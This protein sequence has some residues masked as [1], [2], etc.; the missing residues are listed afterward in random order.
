[1][2]DKLLFFDG[3]MGTMLQNKG[4][5]LGQLP[6]VLN[7]EQK[8]L[9]K[10]IH[11]SYVD[12]GADVITTNTF[13]ANGLK[14][15]GEP[16]SLEEIVKAAISAAKEVKPNYVALDIGPLGKLLEPAGDLS[17]DDAYQLFKEIAV[18][19]EKYQVDCVLIETM[20]DLLET[21]AAVLAVK[22]N[23]KLP[24]FVT[25][26][27]DETGRTF[28]GTDPKTATI[29]LNGL[30]VDGFGVNCS[31]GPKELMP[32]IKEI[33]KYSEAAVIVQPN[34]GLPKTDQNGN[35]YYDLT[36]EEYV[37]YMEIFYQAG[38]SV[39]G[40]C[41]GTTDKY[42]KALTE[43][44]KKAE[45]IKRTV[46]KGTYVTSYAKTVEI[47]KKIQLIGER[48]NPAGK[49]RLKKALKENDLDYILKEAIDQRDEGAT[50]LDVCVTLP[51]IDEV[52]MMEQV[53]KGIQSILDIPLQIDSIDYQTLERACRIYNGKPLINS[54]NG[55]K[56]SM[57]QIF[58]I[59][60]KYG[61]A[62]LGLTL[63]QKGIPKKAEERLAVAKKIIET[64]LSYGLKREDILIDCLTLTA[65]AQQEEVFETIK[66]L[67][68]IKELGHHTI[69]GVS[70]ISFGLPNRVLLNTTFISACLAAGLDAPIL[71]T[72][73]KNIMDMIQAF[74][75]LSNEDLGSKEYIEKFSNIVKEEIKVA[76]LDLKMAVIKGLK[77]E[78]KNITVTLL[79]EKPG[80]KI[81]DEDLI[82]A[83][84][85]VGERFEKK[86][87]F[88]PQLIQSAE[89]VSNSF[90][91][92]KEKLTDAELNFK[93]KGKIIL[94]TV[95]GDIHDI[96]KNIVKVLLENFGYKVYDLGRDVS[97]EKIIE[98]ME[99]EKVSIVGLSALMTT[100][101]RSMEK[102][103]K[104]IRK[105]NL[106]NTIIVGGAVLTQEYADMIGADYYA[107]DAQISIKILEEILS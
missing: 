34:A 9:I 82:P 81:V 21:K 93:E 80:L 96:G 85:I 55:K 97:S 100:T 36:V 27:F 41:C 32:I 25:M 19:G 11:Q 92:L 2:L 56:E 51:E 29:V 98:V 23:T 47:G 16:Y 78:A 43:K 65:S 95:K 69:L 24:V 73:E 74:K 39:L 94:A 17:F 91:I 48:L 8:A 1:M 35:T 22:E 64:G 44:L 33:V 89:A 58:P 90:N 99:K 4:L 67:K 63:D 50:I 15:T 102:I 28:T 83:L 72:K 87:I 104:D 49:K 6:E 20:S 5:K 14:F 18:L 86:Q 7:I 77:E 59:A 30:A 53:I 105:K 68:L 101:V 76:D 26:T 61:C 10:S 75:V 40:G 106:E 42:I 13:G 60:K 79:K 45:K 71:N 38:V 12:A 46:E 62:V 103:I 52:T 57:E 66:S 3:A 31:L 88:L 37:E 54:V 70:N 107:K 84:K